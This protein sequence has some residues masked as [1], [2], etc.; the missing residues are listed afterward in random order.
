MG[1]REEIQTE[2]AAAFNEELA[3]AVVDFSACYVV[4][5]GWDPVTE[6]GNETIVT[7]GGRGILAAYALSR[8]DGVN[9]LKGDVRLIALK[10]EV[11]AVPKEGHTVTAPD[12]IIGM[13][14]AY[15]I[16]SVKVDPAAASYVIQLRRT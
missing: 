6:T 9:I 10:N 8:I 12:L 7:Y 14:Q 16:I 4:R 11:S 3:D 2:I 1:I 15:T 13:H 5:S